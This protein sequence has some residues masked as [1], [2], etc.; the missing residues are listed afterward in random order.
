MIAATVWAEGNPPVAERAA[1]IL[2]KLRYESLVKLETELVNTR[3]IILRRASA[4]K[5]ANTD[6]AGSQSATEVSNLYNGQFFLRSL[7]PSGG[8]ILQ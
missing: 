2:T 3:Q 6:N 7:I 4:V 5:Q 1:F 8:Q